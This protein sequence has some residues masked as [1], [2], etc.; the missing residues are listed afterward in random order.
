MQVNGTGASAATAAPAAG[1]NTR[2]GL[3]KAAEQFEAVFLRQMIGAMRSA[4]L[5]EGITDSSA[6][7]Q[8]QTM[9]DSRTADSLA[10]TGSMGIAQLLVKQFGARM[11]DAPSPTRPDGPSKTEGQ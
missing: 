2:A 4:S 6:T 1:S 10:A 9:A 8:F 3:A 7:E 5:A 11:A